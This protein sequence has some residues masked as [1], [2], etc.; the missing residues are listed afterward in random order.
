MQGAGV[1]ISDELFNIRS[2]PLVKWLLPG[3]PEV[4]LI[5]TLEERDRTLYG[6]WVGLSSEK[7]D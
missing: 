3:D 2:R 6:G 7:L 5:A 1:L 4:L